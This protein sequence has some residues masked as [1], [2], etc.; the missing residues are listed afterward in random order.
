[1][2]EVKEVVVAETNIG[3]TVLCG[4]YD[5]MTDEGKNELLTIGETYLSQ[6]SSVGEKNLINKTDAMTFT[7][8]LYE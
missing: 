3:I 1:M 4:N 5:E 7:N 8:R 6:I 2:S